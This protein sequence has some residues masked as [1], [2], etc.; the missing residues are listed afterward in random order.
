MTVLHKQSVSMVRSE[1]ELSIYLAFE[2]LIDDLSMEH[3]VQA[4]AGC[5]HR[6][7]TRTSDTTRRSC[8]GRDVRR[9]PVYTPQRSLTSPD[10]Y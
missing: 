5:Q 2:L 3:T 8:I 4:S 7:G 10:S 9:A 6:L 1:I